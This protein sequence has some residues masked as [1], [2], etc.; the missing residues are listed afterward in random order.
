MERTGLVTPWY[1]VPE[2]AKG[3]LVDWSVIPEGVV[4]PCLGYVGHDVI[5]GRIYGCPQYEDG[6]KIVTSDLDRIEGGFAYTRNSK[7]ALIAQLG[8]P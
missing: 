1:S 2:G 5:V 6:T 8:C 4:D 7:Y 3:V